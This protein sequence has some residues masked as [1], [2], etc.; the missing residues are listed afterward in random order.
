MKGVLS[1]LIYES[2]QE[3][4]KEITNVEKTKEG[5]IKGKKAKDLTIKEWKTNKGIVE[6]EIDKEEIDKEE[7]DK[8]E[9]DKERFTKDQIKNL[10]EVPSN[11]IYGDYSLPCFYF[12]KIFKMAP[13][14]IAEVIKE[15]I[16]MMDT[17]GILKNLEVV[18][19]FL[20]LYL[21]KENHIKKLLFEGRKEDFG[22]GKAG[23][24]QTVCIDYS[25]PNIAKNF[26]VGHLRTTLI[27]N[28]LYHIY[29]KLGYQVI[30]INHLGDWGTQFG[31]LIVAYQKWSNKEA[32]EEKGIEELLRIYIKFSKESEQNLE[33]E[34][35][36]RSWFVKMEQGEKEALTIWKWFKEISMIEFERIYD[37]LGVS[38]DYYTGESF[39]MDKVPDLVRELMEKHLLSE[40]EGAKIVDL[41]QFDMPP[42]MIIKKDGSSIYHSRDLAAVLY[43]KK[44]Y[45]FDKC[46]YV[47][48]QE[49]KLHFEQVFK[50]I[51]LM[52][53]EWS[54][55][56]IHV[57]YGLVRLQGV[58]LSSRTGNIVYAED[59]LT[60]A[61]KRALELIHQKNPNLDQPKEV[62]RKIGI[63]AIIFHDLFHQRMKDVDF[64]W[65][66]VLSFEG[67]TGPYVQYTYARAKSILKK[68][69]NKPKIDEVD[70]SLLSDVTTYSLLKIISEYKESIY[71]AANRFEPSVIA[72]YTILLSTAFNKFYH[73]C[74][75]L[76][77]DENLRD[78][79]LIVVDLT[80]EITKDAMG[81]LGIEC[82]EEM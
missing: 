67:T 44:Q 58:K 45:Q 74:N 15:K 65:E 8:E 82:P 49:Q 55:N 54:Q 78:A 60:E 70:V 31:K 72:R 29:K 38:F 22:C 43:R 23:L 80:Q 16:K 34:E 69:E 53:Y 73:E 14:L 20:N 81:L 76:N 71:E 66:D 10:L 27:G 32:V 64:S 21:N 30:R 4:M 77:A 26:H 75:I 51:E 3:M 11:Q 33:L 62:A 68:A 50:V 63:G 47:T 57:P 28:S 61:I 41:N 13:K 6:E 9:I 48:G 79:R 35:E 18:N 19:G 36:A 52:G 56:L 24:A 39:Y 5:K 2:C 37:L 46:I 7:I 12:T 25:S 1:D 42:C 40:S 17:E 59:I